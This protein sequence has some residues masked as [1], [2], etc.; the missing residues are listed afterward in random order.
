L[1]NA[2]TQEEVD[3]LLTGFGEIRKRLEGPQR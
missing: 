1:S 3:T 2:H